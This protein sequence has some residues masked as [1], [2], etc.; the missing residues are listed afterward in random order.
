[1][2][3]NVTHWWRKKK[4]HFSL[5]LGFFCAN[6]L[7]ILSSVLLPPYGPRPLNDLRLKK[8][9]KLAQVHD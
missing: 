4:K 7:E 6:C 9:K 1:M 5:F 2:I 8:K 3:F